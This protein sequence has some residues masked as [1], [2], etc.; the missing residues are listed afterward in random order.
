[1]PPT[2]GKAIRLINS[3]PVL[4]RY[5]YAFFNIT[6]SVYANIRPLMQ[7]TLELLIAPKAQLADIQTLVDALRGRL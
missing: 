1:M 5:F 3:E 2:I 7:D 6:T 4:D